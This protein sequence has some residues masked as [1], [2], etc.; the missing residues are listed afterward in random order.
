[1]QIAS[2]IIYGTAWKAEQTKSLVVNAVLQGFRAI[3][4]AGQPKHYREDLVGDALE[5]L[6]KEHGIKRADLFLQTKYTSVEGQDPKLAIPY[7]PN[8]P[9][10][11]Q[12]QASLE[13][14][15][16]NLKTT[17]LDSYLLHSPLKTVEQTVEAWRALISLQKAGKVRM[18]GVSNTYDVHILHELSRERAVEIVQNRWYEGNDW[19]RQVHEFCRVNGIMYQSFWT[20]SGSPSLVN[21]PAL[22]GLAKV[23]GC[24]P[25]QA[26]FKFAQLEQVI[27]LSG[28]TS[29]LH[30]QQDV[31]AE[32]IQL[33]PDANDYLNSLRKFVRG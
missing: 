27:P 10:S 18:I 26:V 32:R 8:D 6:A 12:I 4:T 5:I 31:A 15:L 17:Y 2:K 16:A 20:L 1:M 29:T 11:D 23:A 19:D 13:K 24:T 25:E 30:M 33:P 9:I 14:S 22:R 3:D 28:T 21:H 7:N